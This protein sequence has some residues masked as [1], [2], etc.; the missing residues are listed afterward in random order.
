MYKFGKMFVVPPFY[1]M[2]LKLMVK[3]FVEF[4]FKFECFDILAVNEIN[5]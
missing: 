1:I 4:W 3:Y 5:V 2:W